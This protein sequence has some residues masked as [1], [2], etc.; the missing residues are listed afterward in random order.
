MIST[1]IRVS[2]PASIDD[3]VALLTAAGADSVVVG[4]GTWV[5][6]EMSRGERT[7]THVIELRRA[8]LDSIDL[9]GADLVLGATCTYDRLR[10]SVQV[11]RHAPV[12]ADC[13]AG[14]TG[15]AQIR[16]WG[17]IGGSACYARPASDV[18]GLLVGLDATLRVRGPDG[19]RDIKAADFFLAASH[20]A[21]AQNEI[22]TQIRLP[23]PTD[24]P[25]RAGYY[26]LKFCASSWPIATATA[27]I[28]G[29]TLRVTLGAI[30]PVPVTVRLP[31]DASPE[32]ISEALAEAVCDPWSDVLADGAYR[33]RVA[34]TV[35][36]RAI[37]AISG[38]DE[39]NQP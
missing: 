27:V 21:L 13:A 28:D 17:T 2:L 24:Q 12:L 10:D 33:R 11:A 7:P 38:A 18:P 35:A 26:K 20:T 14:I 4:G 6:P 30:S 19:D 25:L 16:G 37:A 5:V 15:G 8:S 34:P 29:E 1:S 36:A 23:V 9:D 31:C 32:H 39:R 22:L 3:A